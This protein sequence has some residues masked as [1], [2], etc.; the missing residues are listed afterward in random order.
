MITAGVGGLIDASVSNDFGAMGPG[1]LSAAVHYMMLA[2]AEAAGADDAAVGI[3][4]DLQYT[5]S[6][7]DQLNLTIGEAILLDQGDAA[8]DD[9]NTTHD[10]TYIQLSL[11][12]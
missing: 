2:D 3:E 4:I 12:I 10:W 8:A 11:N 9:S 6:L 1:S 5:I 7:A